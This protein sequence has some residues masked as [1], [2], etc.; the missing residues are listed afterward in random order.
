[1]REK[2]KK[3]TVKYAIVF[4]VFI[5]IGVV[6]GVLFWYASGEKDEIKII[7]I[8]KTA[9][10]GDFWVELVSGAESAAKEYQAELEVLAPEVEKD[11]EKQKRCIQKAIRMKPDVIAVSPSL[12][13][14]M[15]DVVEGVTDAGIPLVFIDSELDKDIETSYISTDNVDIGVK[16]GKKVL[17]YIED[18]T[19]IAIMS[20]AKGTSTAM[21]REE[22]LRK[23]LGEEEKR[24]QTVLYCES[25]YGIACSLTKEL[26]EKQPDIDCIVGLNL[27]STTG[28]AKA[29]KEMGLGGKVH[30]IGIDSAREQIE[31]ME[32]GIIDALVVQNPFYMGYFGIKTAVQ[33]ARKQKVEPIIYSQTEVI[34][35]DNIYSLENEK[36]LFPF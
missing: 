23:G 10:E 16:T 32:Q 35:I 24:I 13:T 25:D 1:M 30:V 28:V 27:P 4:G 2:R 33:I 17:E 3:N 15:T 31:Y 21:Q 36:L 12:Y 5:C 9:D 34:T 26:L 18:D 11:V 20:Q 19:K 29:V 7:Y 14:G 22:G 8:P 6:L